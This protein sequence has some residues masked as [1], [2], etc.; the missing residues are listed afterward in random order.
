[1]NNHFDFDGLNVLD[2]FAGT[3]SIGM[4]FASRGAMHV[5]MVEKNFIHTEFIKRTV[6]DFGMENISVVKSD[7]F[8]YID[9]VS[10]EFDMVF[11]DPPYDM[12]H[13]EDI[14]VRILEKIIIPADGWFI[15]EHSKSNHFEH[16]PGFAEHRSYGSVNFSFFRKP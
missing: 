12:D 1:M 6:R 8:R 16:L 7:V 4:E 2:L 13:F 9:K 11:A 3:G 14:P 5:E 15:L 10:L